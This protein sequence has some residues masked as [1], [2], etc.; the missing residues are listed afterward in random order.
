MRCRSRNA[1]L[2]GACCG[3]TAAAGGGVC[4]KAETPKTITLNAA[5]T[6]NLVI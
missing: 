3:G 1:I 4:A 6:E 5:A 2:N